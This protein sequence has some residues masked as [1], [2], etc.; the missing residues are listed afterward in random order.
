MTGTGLVADD[1][2]STRASQAHVG[3]HPSMSLGMRLTTTHSTAGASTHQSSHRRS[4]GHRD[5]NPLVVIKSTA[6][7]NWSM[8]G[9]GNTEN[10]GIVRHCPVDLVL[11][12]YSHHACAM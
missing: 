4:M 12:R 7:V 10:T 9:L 2:V 5:R 3:I 1:V 6:W 8:S 11:E